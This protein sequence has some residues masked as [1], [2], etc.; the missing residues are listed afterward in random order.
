M[1]TAFYSGMSATAARMLGDKGQQMTLRKRTPGT[2][3][4]GTAV[5]QTDADHTVTGAV[6]AYPAVVIDG[7]RIQVGDKKVILA[8]EGMTVEP[9]TGDTL[10][11][12]STWNNIVAV[13]P[14]DPA[15]TAVVF[16]LQVRR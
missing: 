15:G 5:T 1:N 4:P 16:I 12:G 14:V 7:T 6:F 3:T 2:Y 11:I 13:K 10:L 8:A 9:D